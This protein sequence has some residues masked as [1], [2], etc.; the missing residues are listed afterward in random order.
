[1]PKKKLFS[2]TIHDCK[3]ETFRS[4]GPGGQNQNKVE[5]GVH[6]RH[7]PSG[8]VAESREHRTQ[9]ENKRAAFLRLTKLPQFNY[10]IGQMT[11]K[12]KTDEEVT[13]Q[14]GQDM[15]DS[16]LKVE[17]KSNGKW[18]SVSDEG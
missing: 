6:I 17:V 14:V 16:N 9:L 10:W 4:G 2:V 13:R 18:V 1:M 7:L 11:G 3:V 8:S 12:I 5:S 15:V